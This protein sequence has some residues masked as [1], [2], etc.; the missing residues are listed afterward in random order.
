MFKVIWSS[1][2]MDNWFWEQKQLSFKFAS[3]IGA[4]GTTWSGANVLI[5]KKLEDIKEYLD[6]R[7]SFSSQKRSSLIIFF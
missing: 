3:I 7:C 4:A 6:E 2:V 1:Y 5:F